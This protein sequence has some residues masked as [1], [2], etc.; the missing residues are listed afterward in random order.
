MKTTEVSKVKI[1]HQTNNNMEQNNN[2][3]KKKTYFIGIC[4]METKRCDK[5]VDNASHLHNIKFI[6][7][8]KN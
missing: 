3:F 5:L 8:K 2:K 4:N 7:A 1:F 6:R